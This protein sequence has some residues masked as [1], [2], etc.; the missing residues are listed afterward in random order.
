M[1]EK[2]GCRVSKMFWKIFDIKTTAEITNNAHEIQ[3]ILAICSASRMLLGN[4]IFFLN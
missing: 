4:K 3:R 2:I 1:I